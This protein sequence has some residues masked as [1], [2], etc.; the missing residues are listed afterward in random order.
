MNYS[1]KY[2]FFWLTC[3][4]DEFGLMDRR[5]DDAES[6]EENMGLVDWFATD[7]ERLIG[8]WSGEIDRDRFSG[9]QV[10]EISTL[11]RKKVAKII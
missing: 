10:N 6:L 8:K 5:T 4:L 2:D 9:F 7:P 3:C 1:I 11:S